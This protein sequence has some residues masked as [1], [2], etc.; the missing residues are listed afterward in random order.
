M[1]NYFARLFLGLALLFP[2]HAF[3]NNIT[4]AAGQSLER[5]RTV[6]KLVWPILRE[7]DKAGRIYYSVPCA[8]DEGYPYYPYP[9][10][11]LQLRTPEK[12]ITGLAAIR[13]I[14]EDEKSNMI[15]QENPVGVINIQIGKIPE[16]ILNTKILHLTLT[17]QEQYHEWFAVRAIEHSEEVRAVTDKRSDDDPSFPIS[18]LSGYSTDG[19]HLP[20]SLTNMTFDD[21]L[22]LAAQTFR[23]IVVFGTCTEHK[24]FKV[25]FTGGYNYTDVYAQP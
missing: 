20:S 22:D 7:A 21:A 15:V 10:P 1:K 9:F 19:P 3:A 2:V 8:P 24:W 11:K 25:Y 4:Q 14:F 17:Q 16:T 23:G 6:L 18:V 12:G 5:E 13:Q